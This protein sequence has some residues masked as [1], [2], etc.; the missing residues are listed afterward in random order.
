MSALD[1]E[2]A[3]AR[4]DAACA[5]LPARTLPLAE[6]LDRVCAQPVRAACD[7][8]PFDQ[9]SVDGYALRA[10]GLA[11]WPARLPLEGTVAAGPLAEAPRLAEGRAC[12]IYTGGM[13]PQGADAVARQEWVERGEDAITVLRPVAPGLDLRRRGEELRAGTVLVEA[14]ERLHA[15]RIAMLA[16]AGVDELAVHAAP[17]IHVLV[18]GDEIVPAGRPLRLGQVYDA[19]GPLIGAWLRRK[20]YPPPIVEPVP[21]REDAVHDALRRAFA[22]ADLVLTVGGVSVGD[23]DL[24]APQAEKLGAQRQ[25][26]RVAQKPGKP[27]YVARLGHSL[28][29]GLPGNPASVTINLAVFVS[30]AL[31][32]LEGVAAPAPRLRAGTLACDAEADAERDTWLRVQSRIDEDGRLLLDPL[33]YQASHMISNLAAADAL[34]WLPKS[35]RTVPAG[36]RVRCLDLLL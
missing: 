34:A 30:R 24:I 28:L 25:F 32:R 27:L 21:D 26:W 23:R 1:I 29:M 4:L 12:R 36:T 3:W 18:S 15:G 17:R 11:Q 9:S 8:P 2:S 20:G 13:I 5:A 22:G 31:D 10:A 35:P 16:A 19:N 6:A 7:L 14:G 33:P